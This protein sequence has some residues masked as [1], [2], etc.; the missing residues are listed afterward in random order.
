LL[1]RLFVLNRSSG[2]RK[3]E[4]SLDEQAASTGAAWA[5]RAEA[6]NEPFS[7][8]ERLQALRDAPTDAEQSLCYRDLVRVCN[9]D[10]FS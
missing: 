5:R 4:S 7:L 6:S 2:T 3:S 1:P 10:C 8:I 9:L